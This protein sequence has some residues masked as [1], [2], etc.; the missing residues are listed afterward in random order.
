MSKIP[1]GTCRWINEEHSPVG[2]YSCSMRGTKVAATE[3][4]WLLNKLPE[5]SAPNT[6]TIA[7]RLMHT[8]LIYPPTLCISITFVTS[9][10]DVII[11]C[12]PSFSRKNTAHVQESHTSSSA[13]LPASLLT[14]INVSYSYAW[15]ISR[16]SHP[17]LRVCDI[18]IYVHTYI[19]A[20]IHMHKIIY[21]DIYTQT[22]SCMSAYTHSYRQ[23]WIMTFWGP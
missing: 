18:C 12:F 7:L 2:M 21:T 9:L 16:I 15:T 22:D 10:N 8:L 13:H 23:G 20:Y 14:N 17:K 4:Q 6:Q 11:I 3:G 5:C 1:L 19:S